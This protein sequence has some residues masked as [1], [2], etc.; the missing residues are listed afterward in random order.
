MLTWSQQHGQCQIVRVAALMVCMLQVSSLAKQ[1][2]ARRSAAFVPDAPGSFAV[3]STKSGE[4][5]S[6]RNIVSA[7]THLMLPYEGAAAVFTAH[8]FARHE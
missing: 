5:E 7:S 2:A 4:L 3:I 6:L 8:H 1:P